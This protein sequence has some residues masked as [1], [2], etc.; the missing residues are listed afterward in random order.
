MEKY[1]FNNLSIIDELESRYEEE[2]RAT[3][4]FTETKDSSNSSQM[5]L[6]FNRA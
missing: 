3:S 2:L 4:V 6:D 1:Q 5:N